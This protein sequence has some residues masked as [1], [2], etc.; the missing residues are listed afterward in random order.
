MK[1]KLLQANNHFVV[2]ARLKWMPWKHWHSSSVRRGLATSVLEYSLRLKPTLVKED[3]INDIERK[4]YNDPL[5]RI[6]DRENSRL[7]PQQVPGAPS[8]LPQEMMTT[9]SA[10]Y[11][12]SPSSMTS[13]PVMQGQDPSQM[14]A[15]EQALGSTLSS[16][17]QE[18]GDD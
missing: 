10:N 8:A 11:M 2:T 18:G 17:L 16:F 14:F 1:R 13:G 7:R 6:A 5:A 12:L 9:G 4:I 15:G 3:T